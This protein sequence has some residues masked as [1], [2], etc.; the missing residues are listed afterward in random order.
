[1]GIVSSSLK[2]LTA[3]IYQIAQKIHFSC[4]G[5]FRKFAMRINAASI[6]QEE[7]DKYNEKPGQWQEFRKT[8]LIPVA[9]MI[10]SALV[11]AGLTYIIVFKP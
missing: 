11:G 5:Y 6:T 2:N 3:K 7:I 9:M 1:M 8:W 4:S 10:I